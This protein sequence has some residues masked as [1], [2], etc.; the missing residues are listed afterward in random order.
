MPVQNTWDTVAGDV[1]KH[2]KG[3]ADAFDALEVAIDAGAAQAD[4]ATAA[5]GQ[6]WLNA[7]KASAELSL[8]PA[9]LAATLLGKGDPYPPRQ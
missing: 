8:A 7:L 4:A 2:L 5:A 6:I 3:A 1:Q 9:R